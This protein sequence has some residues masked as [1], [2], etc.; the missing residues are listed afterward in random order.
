MILKIHLQT[1]AKALNKSE[2]LEED[3][4]KNLPKNHTLKQQRLQKELEEEQLKQRMKEEGADYDRERLL[5]VGAD[6]AERWER[7]KRKKNPDVG[8]SSYEDATFRQYNRLSKGIKMDNDRYEREKQVMGEEAF[9]ASRGTINIGLHKDTPDD[10]ENM[11]QDLEKQV[12]KRDKY[13]RRRMYDDDNDINYINERN[14]KFNKKLERFY[15]AY[16]EEIKQNLERG[17]AV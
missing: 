9:Y 10:I 3:R 8:F 13:S 6:D 12:A 4:I 16:T 1:E 5:T 14:M 11:V 2:V 15:G 7:K 17:T